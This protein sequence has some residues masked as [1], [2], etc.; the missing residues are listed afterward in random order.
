MKDVI[1]LNGE[2]ILVISVVLHNTLPLSNLV[3]CFKLYPGVK[4]RMN[5]IDSGAED[6]FILDRETFIS[7]LRY[8]RQHRYC[9]RISAML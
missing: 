9:H 6:W 3:G 2:L 7:H 5:A 4:C 8:S 1:H